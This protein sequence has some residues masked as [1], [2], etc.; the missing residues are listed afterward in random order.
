MAK[1]IFHVGDQAGQGQS[2]KLLNNFLSAMALTATSEAI[3][4]GLAQGLKM[5]TMLE[6]LNV[7]TGRNTATSDKFPNQVATG[8]FAAGFYTALMTKDLKLY[9]ESVRATGTPKPLIELLAETWKKAD[10]T[11]PGSDF[12]QIYQYVR[13]QG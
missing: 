12:T 9:L 3:L 8:K 7:S 5:E 1:N 13:D 4:Y 10:Q 6:V 11:L 2:M